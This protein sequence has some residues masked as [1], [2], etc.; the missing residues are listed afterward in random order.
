M[1]KFIVALF[2]GAVFLLGQSFLAYSAKGNA[3]V[4]TEGSVTKVSNNILTINPKGIFSNELNLEI[5]QNTQ[6]EAVTSLGQLQQGDRIKVQYFER[7]GKKVA[8]HITKV[9]LSGSGKN[10]NQT[11]S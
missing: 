4:T 2:V 6:L 11:Q 8:S 3:P 9:S 10:R 5:N 1:K 7:D